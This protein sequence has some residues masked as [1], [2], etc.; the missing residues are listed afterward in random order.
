MKK[1]AIFGAAVVVVT[2][3]GTVAAHAQPLDRIYGRWSENQ[4]TCR[5]AYIEFKR[6][7]MVDHPDPSSF[8]G[9]LA[10]DYGGEFVTKAQYEGDLPYFYV[11]QYGR[12]GSITS[13]TEYELVSEDTLHVARLTQFRGGQVIYDKAIDNS[14]GGVFVR[15]K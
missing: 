1:T 8:S 13:K 14:K 12:D 3:A 7:A 5:S 9:K 6:G 11:T 15:C 2:L 4:R 10:K